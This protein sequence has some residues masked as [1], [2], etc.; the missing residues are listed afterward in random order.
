MFDNKDFDNHERVDFFSD[1]DTGLSAIIAIHSTALGPAFGGA[2]M[3]AYQTPTNALEDALRLSRSMTYKAA[4]CNIPLGGGKTVIIAHTGQ[5]KS[6]SLLRA[7]GRFVEGLKGTNVIADD[8]GISLSDLQVIRQVTQYTAAATEASRSILPVTAYGVLMSMEA[9]IHA[10]LGKDDLS[11]LK[12]AVQGLGAVG[13]PLCCYLNERGAELILSDINYNRLQEVA[14]EFGATFVPP[15][16][17]FEQA[18]DIFSPCALGGVL[19]NKTIGQLKAALVCGGANNQ[20]SE[21]EDAEKLHRRGIVYIPDY[22]ASAG[23]VIDYH[24]ERIDDSPTAVLKAVEQ[25]REITSDILHDAEVQAKSPLD[26]C[27]RR[28]DFRLRNV[29]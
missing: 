15:D 19:N 17:I 18:V 2:R 21:P 27:N 25:I 10:V 12:I 1:P 5:D 24:Q 7:V 28:V 3:F 23:G 4:I 11:G 20:L 6:K 16:Q 9:A 13:Y 29:G 22:L 14:S 8:V 26:I